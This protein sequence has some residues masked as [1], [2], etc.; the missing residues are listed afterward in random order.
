VDEA[1]FRIYDQE[2]QP[3]DLR[4]KEIS[5]IVVREGKGTVRCGFK[6]YETDVGQAKALADAWAAFLQEGGK[7]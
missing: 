5:N 7:T 6:Y 1:I 2:G 4:L 3:L